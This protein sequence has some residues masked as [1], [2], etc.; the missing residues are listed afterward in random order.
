LAHTRREDVRK[1]E[2]STTERGSGLLLT[3]EKYI[4]VMSRLL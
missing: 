1:E 3:L 2:N 4:K